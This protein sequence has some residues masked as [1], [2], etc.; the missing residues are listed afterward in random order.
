[1]PFE[2][3]PNQCEQDTARNYCLNHE[4]IR[5]NTNVI[6]FALLILVFELTSV[7]LAYISC[8]LLHWFGV[9]ASLGTLHF[10]SSIIV[11]LIF[12]KKTCII[13]IEL[14]QHYAPE[15]VRRRCMMM[16]SC[17]EYAILALQKHGVVIGLYKTYIRLVKKC[18]GGIYS[19]DY[20]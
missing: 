10:L 12:L 17:S 9:T 5:P 11:L 16:P 8:R 4:L 13:L 15:N 19:I 6:T 20:P 1:M 18:K 14:Y 2:E 3:T 7:V